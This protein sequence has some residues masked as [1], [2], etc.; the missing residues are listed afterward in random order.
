MSKRNLISGHFSEDL[1]IRLWMRREE[2]RIIDFRRQ[3]KMLREQQTSNPY[4]IQEKLAQ[5]TR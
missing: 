3:E 4:V 1:Q 5:M 2:Q